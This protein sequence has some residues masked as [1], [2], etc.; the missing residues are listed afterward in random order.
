MKPSSF[1]LTIVAS[2]VITTPFAHATIIQYSAS[3]SGLN[4]S[5]ANA[6]TGTGLALV[7]IDDALHTMAIDT[8][9]SGLTGTTTAAHIHCCTAAPLTGLAGVATTTP[10]FAGFPLGVTSGTYSIL[11][12]MTLSASYNPSFVNA[13]GSIGAAETALFNGMA[14]GESY[15]NIHSTFAPGGEIRGFLT[16]VTEPVPEPASFA[17]IG[18]G[19]AGMGFARRKV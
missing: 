7:T 14:A 4:E 5:P 3:L 6:S 2:M 1:A 8:Q 13:Y 19:L 12:D 9:F 15:L 16:Q 17:L 11:L 18:L 10:S